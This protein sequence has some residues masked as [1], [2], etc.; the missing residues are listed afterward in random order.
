M[1]FGVTR[2][3]PDQSGGTA[4]RKR[5]FRETFTSE[6][7]GVSYGLAAP[8]RF[9]RGLRGGSLFQSE[10]LFSHRFWT[11]ITHVESW[12]IMV[13]IDEGARNSC[14]KIARRDVSEAAGRRCVNCDKASSQTQRRLLLVL[15]NAPSMP[16]SVVVHQNPRL[17]I[18]GSTPRRRCHSDSPSLSTNILQAVGGR[19]LHFRG[20][21]FG[22]GIRPQCLQQQVASD[23]SVEQGMH[24]ACVSCPTAI[25]SPPVRR[26]VVLHRE[27]IASPRRF[28][29]LVR[30]ITGIVFFR[31]NPR[32]LFAVRH[33]LS[34][35][36]CH[37]LD[38][39][40]RV[41]SQKQ[42]QDM[43]PFLGSPAKTH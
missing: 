36:A 25:S 35:K 16:V 18:E 15:G 23:S 22:A 1:G 3:G 40:W 31:R 17:S 29:K 10:K 12:F 24:E 9:A 5:R 41:R 19:S 37:I 14:A 20:P 33:G 27:S 13:A 34:Q 4:Q 8:R 28:R 38:F 43:G 26:P 39:F 30:S 11:A 42:G 6:K 21:A 2:G 7:Q 32:L